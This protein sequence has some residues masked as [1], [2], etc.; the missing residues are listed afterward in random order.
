MNLCSPGAADDFLDRID[1]GCKRIRDNPYIGFKIR[2]ESRR[3][4]GVRVQIVGSYLLLYK[5][6][7]NLV[8]VIHIVDGRTKRAARILGRP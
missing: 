4:N 3:Y 6:K 1:S 7:G 2:G 5:V 8:E